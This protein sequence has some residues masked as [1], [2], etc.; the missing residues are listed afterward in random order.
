MN[1][2]VSVYEISSKTYFSSFVYII[3]IL[4]ISIV[5]FL[6]PNIIIIFMGILLFIANLFLIRITLYRKN[7]PPV[8]ISNNKITISL[9]PGRQPVQINIRDIDRI[10]KTPNYI[11]IWFK[12]ENNNIEKISLSL[13]IFTEENQ[14]EIRKYFESLENN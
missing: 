5:F 1:E 6:I 13:N 11:I 9:I 3:I 2:N 14:L 4:I 8:L 12:T 10:E 7:N